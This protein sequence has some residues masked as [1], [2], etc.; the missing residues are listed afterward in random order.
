MRRPVASTAMFAT[1]LGALPRPPVPGTAPP[2]AVLDA[3]LAAQMEHGL[4]PLVAAGWGSWRDAAGRSDRLVKAVVAGP[5][6]SG[7]GADVV[8]AEMSDLAAAG[9]AW[10]EVWEEVG[11]FDPTAARATFL[12]A[13]EVLGRAFPDGG[14]PHRSLALIGGDA[15]ALGIE[16]VLAGGYASLAVDLID[17]PDHWRLVSALPGD[18]GVVA[19]ALSVA[20]ATDLGTEVLVWAAQYA[21]SMNGRGS[22]RVGLATAGSMAHL[23]WE[24]A[25]RKLDRL[26]KGAALAAAG[27]E[28]LRRAIDPRAVDIRS[29][30]LGR[31]DPDA[32]KPGRQP[33]QRP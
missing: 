18:R 1:L 24:Q 14:G 26:A 11:A 32:P 8:A 9:C 2:E 6:S 10:I 21:A 7:R 3:V 13:H 20:R 15:S 19:G 5:L 30:A 17:G 16:P 31:F 29:A 25:M 33:R 27:G 4:E 23:T 22:D 28:E 12:R